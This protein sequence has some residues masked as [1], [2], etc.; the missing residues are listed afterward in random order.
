MHVESGFYGNFAAGYMKDDAMNTDPGFKPLG[1]IPDDRSSFYA[2]ELG[3]EKKWHELG[4]TTIFGQYYRNE[5]GSQDRT[6]TTVPMVLPGTIPRIRR[7]SA[8][9]FCK[10]RSPV[11]YTRVLRARRHSGDR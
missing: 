7:R 1:K 4:K 8:G 2:F 3:I 9:A 5:G 10:R 6:V 11:V